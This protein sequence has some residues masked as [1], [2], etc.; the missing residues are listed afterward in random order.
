M[1]S[2][3]FE[4]NFSNI[5]QT[6]R[7]EKRNNNTLQ[8]NYLI[9]HRHEF[10]II[11]SNVIFVATHLFAHVA[12]VNRFFQLKTVGQNLQDQIPEMISNDV[13]QT[14]FTNLVKKVTR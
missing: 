1:S 9:I 14:L 6:N 12:E 11:C 2:T 13:H 4:Q 5:Y 3:V 8:I 10:D 7:I